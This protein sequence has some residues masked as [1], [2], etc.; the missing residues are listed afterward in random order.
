MTTE[1]RDERDRHVAKENR[2]D[3]S[4]LLELRDIVDELGT[5]TKLL[6]Q[7]T[8]T[9]KSMNNYYE[10]KS[11]GKQF[12]DLAELRLEEYRTQVSEMKKDASTTQKAV[13]HN[14]L[15]QLFNPN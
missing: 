1:E 10:E 5:I 13:C 14:V 7:Q 11:H 8:T 4:R 2:K 9:I 15:L 3:V 12:V 6:D